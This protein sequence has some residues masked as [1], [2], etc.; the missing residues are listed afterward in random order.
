MTQNFTVPM[1]VHFDESGNLLKIANYKSEDSSYITVTYHD[2]E[3][4]LDGTETMSN[5][6]VK[7]D[8][9]NIFKLVKNLSYD[10]TNYD[11]DKRIY[12]IPKNNSGATLK[13][14]QDVKNK[15]WIFDVDPDFRKS[16][17]ENQFIIDN[18]MFF[19]I[20]A[21]GDPNILYR[22]IQINFADVVKHKKILKFITDDEQN[23]NIEI[24]THK[25]IDSYTHEVIN[26]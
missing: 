14:Y 3:K 26:E 23:E 9:S 15:K 12:A 19:S 11:V 5:F 7:K 24:Y 8:S 25:K 21:S 18:R 10:T 6:S 22:F 17:F 1:Y 20:T 4:I 16:Y 2:V 13:I